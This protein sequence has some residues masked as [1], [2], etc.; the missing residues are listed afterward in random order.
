MTTKQ[1]TTVNADEQIKQLYQTA[2]P[3]EEQIPWDDLLRLIDE[4]HLDFT[5]YYEGE[6]FIGFTIVYPRPSF[7]WFWYF[8][9]R[10]DLRGRGYGQQILSLVIGHYRGQSLVMDIESTRQASAENRDIRFRRHAFYLRNG[11]CETRLYRGWS[12]IEYTI[13]VMGLGTFT[14][15]D[16]DDIVAE[17]RQY[18]TW[19]TK[20]T[21]TH[22]QKPS[23]Q[24]AQEY[25]KKATL[26]LTEKDLVN[27]YDAGVKFGKSSFW[28]KVG[29]QDPRPNHIKEQIVVVVKLPGDTYDMDVMKSSE[30]PEYIENKQGP[31]E[32]LFWAYLK[33]MLSG[34]FSFPKPQIQKATKDQAEEIANLIMMAMTDECCLY[35]CGDGYGL[36]DFRK[37]MISLVEEDVSQYSYKNTFVAMVFN[38]VVGIA[39]SYDGGRLR[40]LRRAFITAAKE[41]LGKDH[42][43]MDDETQA[44]ELYLDSLAVLPEYR[45]MGIGRKLVIATKKRAERMHLPCVGL[46]VDKDNPE[47]EAFY[48]SVRFQY[49]GDSQWG[50]HPMKHLTL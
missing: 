42:T 25:M 38:K 27:A 4:M 18:W 13:L 35:F 6:D 7:N 11:F 14:M 49:A 33:G 10:E 1:I 39:V 46:L 12:G 34:R 5:A 32:P 24:F 20:N 41:Y 50:G 16:W 28:H 44:G 9:V 19:E 37:M 2:F 36:D 30:Y 22:R 26:P 48:T 43:G 3:E 17:L 23:K 31:G 47:G 8:A 21:L 15:Q 29:K 40:K 45:R